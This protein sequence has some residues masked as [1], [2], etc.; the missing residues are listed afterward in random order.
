MDKPTQDTRAVLRALARATPLLLLVPAAACQTNSS[1]SASATATVAATAT[2]TATSAAATATGSAEVGVAAA[3]DETVAAP[4]PV[5]TGD[6][7]VPINEGIVDTPP[8]PPD[9][10]AETAPPAAVIEDRP[11]PP[12]PADVW[13]P[14]YWWWTPGTKHYSW[15]TGGWRNPPQDQFWTPGE[16]TPNNGHYYWRPGYWA[17]KGNE[18]EAALEHAQPTQRVEPQPPSPGAGYFWAPGYYERRN[19]AYEWRTG[20]WS[21]P[22]H[23]GDTWVVSIYVNV[24]GRYYYHPGRWDHPFAQRGVAYRPDVH[25]RPGEHFLPEPLP[26]RS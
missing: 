22:P 17:P 25:V 7:D 3:D 4:A 19:N 23:D 2:A 12:E 1:T 21:R 5:V 16:W 24:G 10:S 9:Y 6:P 18:A 8:L 11:A 14:G 20:S 15:V 13:V 26:P